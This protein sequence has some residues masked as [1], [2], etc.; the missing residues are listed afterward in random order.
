[1]AKIGSRLLLLLL[2][3]GTTN[4]W[5]QCYGSSWKNTCE[6]DP[7]GDPVGDP[8]VDPDTIPEPPS[9]ISPLNPTS[10][11]SP[12]SPINQTQ[13]PEVK[14]LIQLLPELEVETK[15]E[16]SDNEVKPEH[17]FFGITQ[18]GMR[19]AQMPPQIDLNLGIPDEYGF[20]QNFLFDFVSGSDSWSLIDG[21]ANSRWRG[22]YGHNPIQSSPFS[23]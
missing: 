17:N 8:V 23:D 19:Q 13:T 7:I 18:R 16:K 21:A 22:L 15:V 2:L 9:I 1:M 5:A 3:A 10:P 20:N 4:V 6:N 11:I 12:I 14:S